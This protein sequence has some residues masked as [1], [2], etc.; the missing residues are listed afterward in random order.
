[1]K[2]SLPRAVVVGLAA[3][4]VAGCNSGATTPPP[5]RT[6]TA[7]PPVLSGLHTQTTIGSTV[8]PGPGPGTGDQNPYGLAIAPIT[9]GKLTAGDLVVCNFND[10]AN[11]QGNGTTIVALHPVGG[12]T[13]THVAQNAALKGCDAL[14]LSANDTI[15]TAAFVSNRA[16]IVAPSG[17][18]ISPNPNPA[19]SGPFGVIFSPTTG[20][21]GT[22][23]VFESNANSG[24]VTRMNIT[25]GAVT[26]VDTIISGFTK[27]TGV[28]GMIAGA[29]GLT[30]D[31]N[32]DQ[33][34]VVDGA[35]NRLLAFTNASSIPAGGITV[36]SSSFT[37]PSAAQ[38]RVVSANPA[39]NVPISAALLVNG[40]VVVGNTGDNKMLEFAPS[41]AL[42]ATKLVDAGPTGAIF[43]IVA[44]GTTPA[45]QKIYFNDDNTNTV[46]LISQ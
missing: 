33:L 4:L 36:T 13:P 7:F 1:M 43:G 24:T 34:Y 3:M 14:T 32:G 38:A 27:N 15:Y 26:S 37:G 40:D 25:A 29:S 16:P 28:P 23:S 41:G 42:V 39:I 10:A 8:D 9:A 18:V 22:S 21:F 31:P 44:T 20:P 30:Y 6:G 46:V 11:V 12:A 45:N 5:F 35:A 2:A 19:W 17:A